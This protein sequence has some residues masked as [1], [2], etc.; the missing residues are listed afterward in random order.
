MQGHR[1]Y[2]DEQGALRLREGDYGKTVEGVW[3][4]RPPG[5]HAGDLRNHDIIEHEDETITVS[6]SILAEDWHG[7]LEHGVWRSV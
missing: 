4:A 1:V 7:Y 5:S 2:P 3:M 6:P